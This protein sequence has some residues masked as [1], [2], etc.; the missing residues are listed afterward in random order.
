MMLWGQIDPTVKA[1]EFGWEIGVL[2]SVLAFLAALIMVWVNKVAIPR[3]SREEAREDRQAER[4][5]KFFDNLEKTTAE[6]A[7]A[8]KQMSA[9]LMIIDSTIGRVLTLQDQI[10]KTQATFGPM[11]R[12]ET[13]RLK[14]AATILLVAARNEIGNDKPRITESINHALAMLEGSD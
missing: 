2:V 10:A 3:Q 8:V 14:K 13:V 4:Q 5:L 11:H 6:Q 12:Y 9:G 1:W 7:E